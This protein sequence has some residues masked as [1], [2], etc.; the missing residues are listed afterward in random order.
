MTQ[1]VGA[2]SSLLH[3]FVLDGRPDKQSRIYG[4]LSTIRG[5]ASR[6]PESTR[7]NAKGQSRLM[8]NWLAYAE[9]V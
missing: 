6:F 7:G 8:W 5:N 9:S 4:L 2:G 1:Y 3:N